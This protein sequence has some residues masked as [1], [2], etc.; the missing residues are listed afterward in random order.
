MKMVVEKIKQNVKMYVLFLIINLVVIN[1]V[2]LD[3]I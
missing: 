3:A 2:F 1:A